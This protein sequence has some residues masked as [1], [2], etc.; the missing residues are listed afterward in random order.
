MIAKK[1]EFYTGAGMMAAF[2]VV[3]VIVF[4]PV[5]NGHNGLEYLDALY[6]AIS[7]GSAYYIPKLKREIQPVVN[8]TVELT[9]ALQSGPQ[10]EQT[11]PLFQ[12]SAAVVKVSG[13]TL[14]VSGDLGKI[15][16]NCLA[17]ADAMYANDGQKVS[18]KYGYHEK[19]VMYN[20]W[21]AL[22][23]MDKELKKQEKFKEAKLVGIVKKKAVETSYNYYKIEP[24]KISDRYGI[25]IFSLIFYV[26]YTLWYGFAFMFMF[27]GWGLRLEH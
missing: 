4:S 26:I 10:A 9:L 18:T 6:N 20:W 23:A 17:D 13:S 5:F 19:R 14:T 12:K 22:K 8:K 3:L 1:K 21:M 27:E 2:S 25:V 15:L 24:Q 11:A 7:K 16:G